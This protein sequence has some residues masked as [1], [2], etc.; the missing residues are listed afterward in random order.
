M[1]LIHDFLVS[2]LEFE[3][4]LEP[5]AER[6]RVLAPDLPGFGESEKPSPARYAYGIESFAEAMVDM[7]AG[8]ELGRVSVVGHSLGGAAAI[9]LAAEHPE[10]VERLVLVNAMSY[11]FRLDFRSRLPFLPF[12][13]GLL[14]KQLYG[15]GMC[16]SS[17]SIDI[18]TSSIRPPGERAR[19]P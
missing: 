2:H 5:L 1:L 13:G 11:P 18:T 14:F 15:R 3:G 4:V 17:E 8:L 12:V 10:L 6:F 16:P 19:T 9:T 7:I